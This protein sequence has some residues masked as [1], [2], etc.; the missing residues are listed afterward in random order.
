MLCGRR[1]CWSWPHSQNW[2]IQVTVG[3][4]M[5]ECTRTHSFIICLLILPVSSLFR[6]RTQIDSRLFQPPLQKLISVYKDNW[7]W[8]IRLFSRCILDN[9][10]LLSICFLDTVFQNDM[11]DSVTWHFTCVVDVCNS[12]TIAHHGGFRGAIPLTW[13][14]PGDIHLKEQFEQETTGL[15]RNGIDKSVQ[16]AWGCKYGRKQS[17][18]CQQGL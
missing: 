10:R 4:M 17:F 6:W 15:T 13:S 9:E 18:F 5:L 14:D 7:R 1:D 2:P 16:E 3:L 11:T 8:G 12:S